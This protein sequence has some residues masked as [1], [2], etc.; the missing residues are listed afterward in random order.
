M[1]SIY[2]VE[3]DLREREEQLNKRLQETD[4]EQLQR[5]KRK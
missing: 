2:R 5:K 1:Y 3:K 4:A